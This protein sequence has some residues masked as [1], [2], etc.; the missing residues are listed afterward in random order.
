M[1]AGREP[2][3]VHVVKAVVTNKPV[4]NAELDQ[5]SIEQAPIAAV[6]GLKGLDSRTDGLPLRV[7]D[8]FNGKLD[9]ATDQMVLTI[10]KADDNS[11]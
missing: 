11:R 4:T 2:F 3:G 8:L 10:K 6:D 7:V 1:R 5:V 9:W